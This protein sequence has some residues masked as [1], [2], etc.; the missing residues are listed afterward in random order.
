M[1]ILPAR[2]HDHQE[3][4]VADAALAALGNALHI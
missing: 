2:G 1:S 4:C 3:G